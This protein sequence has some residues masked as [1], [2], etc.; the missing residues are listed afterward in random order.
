MSTPSMSEF[1]KLMKS[2]NERMSATAM[3]ALVLQVSQHGVLV[4][5]GLKSPCLIPLSEF[6]DETLPT[7]GDYVACT[8]V[9]IDHMGQGTLLSREMARRLT[10]V[11][12][13]TEA[14]TSGEIVEAKATGVNKG[15]VMVNV[16][17]CK[18]F[19]PKSLSRGLDLRSVNIGQLLPCKVDKVDPQGQKVILTYFPAIDQA[20]S[21]SRADELATLTEGDL[22][23]AEVKSLT[24]YGAFCTFGTLSGLLHISQIS[25]DRIENLESVVKVGD[26]MQLKVLTIDRDKNRISLSRK[27]LLPKPEKEATT[28]ESN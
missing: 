14:I 17:G 12:A 3:G 25:H 8:L 1:E 2:E 4:D 28:T 11:R 10:G 18:G 9:S 20:A 22:V 23:T 24:P 26:V 19:I 13:L 6:E 16:Q 7:Q 5:A 27:V 15:G 21:R